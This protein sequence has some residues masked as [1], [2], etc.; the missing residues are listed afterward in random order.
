MAHYGMLR[1]YRFSESAEDVRGSAV[2]GIDD[3]K[4]GKIDDVIFDH[5]TGEIRYTVVDTGG[6]L[7]SKK[8]IVPA[9]R[10]R[11]SATHDDDYEVDLN[12]PQIES[13]PAYDEKAIESQDKWADYES[14]Y[15]SSWKVSP[16]QH[17]EGTDR[18]ITPPVSA[19]GGSVTSNLGR[20]WSAF[21]DRLRRDRQEFVSSCSVCSPRAGAK[22]SGRPERERKVS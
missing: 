5:S 16:V 20:R 12:K 9:D 21:E 6:W 10:L 17:R 11:P 7:T 2:Y 3:E 18:N 13:F 15:R 14:R 1:D 8:F 4:L 22:P 19:T